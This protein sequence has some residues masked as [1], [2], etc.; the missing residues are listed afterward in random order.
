[1]VEVVSFGDEVLY[2]VNREGPLLR[3]EQDA[4]DIVG[5]AIAENA[6][7]IA[8]P[9]ARLDPIFFD[10]QTQTAGLM[11]QKFVNYR[12]HVAVVGDVSNYI[13]RSEPFAAFV[14]E[15]NRG[16]QILFISDVSWLKGMLSN[17]EV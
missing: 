4:L 13:E 1:M 3:S 2:V 5:A 10:L 12:L 14:K 9:V 8:L 11:L 15:S 17:D 7:W 6:T 16:H